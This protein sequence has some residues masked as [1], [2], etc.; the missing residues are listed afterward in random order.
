MAKRAGEPIQT[1]LGLVVVAERRQRGP[2]LS[3]LGDS[4][5][6]LRDRVDQLLFAR[7]VARQFRLTRH[8]RPRQTQRLELAG[9]L[10]IAALR[11]LAGPALLLLSFFHPLGEAGFRI[12]E[13]FSGITHVSSLGPG[14]FAGTASQPV[15]DYTVKVRPTL[16]VEP[17]GRRALHPS[18]VR[19]EAPG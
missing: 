4:A 14:G 3:E 16:L 2:L 1:M 18:L 5:I 6:Q 13:P 7:R 11:T 9:T 10:R 17:G 12:D 15:S 8:L 19:H